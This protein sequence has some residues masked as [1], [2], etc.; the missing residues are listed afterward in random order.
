MSGRPDASAACGQARVVKQGMEDETGD[1][2]IRLQ[3][4]VDRAAGELLDQRFVQNR[5]NF[6]AP[7]V[8]HKRRAKGRSRALEIRSMEGLG[9]SLRC[10]HI[11]AQADERE[12]GHPVE[13]PRSPS[14]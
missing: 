6:M 7:D 10:R 11:Q 4:R 9:A 8:R 3:L 1:D 5:C 14:S 12:P 2:V 13:Q